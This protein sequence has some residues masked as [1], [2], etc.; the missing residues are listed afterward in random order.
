MKAHTASLINAIL[1]IAL[2]LWGYFSAES[3]SPTA[4]IPTVFGVILLAL[5]TGV[6][7]ENKVIAHIAVVAT[8][9]ILLGLAM[10]LKAAIG[11]EDT[12][13]MLRVGIMLLSTIV[14]MVFFIKSFIDAKKARQAGS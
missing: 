10:P 5:N 12:M 14:A 13:A 9:L 2:S 1:L 3:P 8:L 4:F 6:R 11:R 7:K